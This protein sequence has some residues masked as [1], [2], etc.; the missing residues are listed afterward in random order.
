M[1]AELDFTPWLNTKLAFQYV[2]YFNFNGSSSN[3][4]GAGRNASDNN[5]YYLL[6]WLAF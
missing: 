1:I 3:Y 5:T 4:D 2:S 6:A